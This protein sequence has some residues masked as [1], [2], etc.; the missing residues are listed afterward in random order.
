VPFRVWV[1][2]G[3][4]VAANYLLHVD[5]PGERRGRAEPSTPNIETRPV[6]ASVFLKSAIT[7]RPPNPN[8]CSQRRYKHRQHRYLSR[9]AALVW[10]VLARYHPPQFF[11]FFAGFQPPPPF[12]W[13]IGNPQWGC[14]HLAHINPDAPATPLGGVGRTKQQ[15]FTCGGAQTKGP[16]HMPQK[17]KHR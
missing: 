7:R 11:Q 14:L 13:C 1:H 3:G 12:R 16:P 9:S 8:M 15:G 4:V 17:D 2:T 5:L 10:L 6:S